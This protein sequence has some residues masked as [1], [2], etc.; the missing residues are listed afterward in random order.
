VEKF[1]EIGLFVLWW[2]GL[3]VASSIGLGTGLHTFMLYLGPHI[4]K[5][6]IV[7]NEWNVVP[8]YRPSR[9][10]VD[11]FANCPPVSEGKTIGF[12]EILFAVQLESIL[13]GFGT[14]IG[15]LPPY[16]VA[17]AARLAG[18]E[19][20]E[21][22]EE[23]KN[24]SEKSLMFRIKRKLFFLLQKYAFLTVTLCASIPNPL[25]DLAGIICGHFLIPFWTFFGAAMLGKAIIKVHLQVLFNI[26]FP[27]F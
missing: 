10:N 4:A 19:E 13:W 11:H 17:R 25:F 21:E 27:L 2:V 3:G 12:L 23:L 18:K 5:V 14:A 22:L 16:F 20:E 7:A 9:W 1:D 24:E 15:E 6:T 26:P 8:E